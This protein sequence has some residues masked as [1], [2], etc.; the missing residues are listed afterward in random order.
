MQ[1]TRAKISLQTMRV[2]S[3][4]K[5]F[6]GSKTECEDFLKYQLNVHSLIFK[7]LNKGNYILIDENK[8]I[9]KYAIE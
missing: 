9:I 3:K 5:A 7:V 6:E 4:Y 8:I 2:I 1:V